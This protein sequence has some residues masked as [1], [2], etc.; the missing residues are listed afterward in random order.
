MKNAQFF[1]VLM[2]CMTVL[3]SCQEEGEGN[4]SFASIVTFEPTERIHTDG[5]D[6]TLAT[7]TKGADIYYTTD[8]KTDPAPG[9][10]NTF[11]YTGAF[12]LEAEGQNDLRAIAVKDGVSNSQIAGKTYIVNKTYPAGR[13]DLNEE[14]RPGEPI[15]S[16][17]DVRALFGAIHSYLAGLDS[18]EK[19]LDESDRRIQLGDYIDLKSL[20]VDAPDGGGFSP[21][22]IAAN[23]EITG[24]GKILR[25]WVVGINSFNGKNDNEDVPHIVFHF[26]NLPAQY[27]MRTSGVSYGGSAMQSYLNEEFQAGLFAAGVPLDEDFVFAP[28][29]VIWTGSGS[30]TATIEDKLWLPTEWEM[31]GFNGSGAG[32]SNESEN[33]ENQ[34]KLEWYIG[35]PLRRQKHLS[36]QQSTAYFLASPR[37]TN[38]ASES[39]GVDIEGTALSLAA[40]E[41]C[42]V[43]PAFCV[44]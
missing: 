43:A 8:G 2:V 13:G 18:P 9:N 36:S 3:L 27:I 7:V 14:F 37:A 1:T 12:K 16:A 19:L 28:K 41:S 22:N 20:D 17:S 21:L 10:E 26:Q 40:Y 32:Y 25:I 5:V 15:T 44:K 39:C 30:D 38:P 6:V 33:D 42:G 29:R 31:F 23:S 11:K 24:H 34:A 4:G 35:A